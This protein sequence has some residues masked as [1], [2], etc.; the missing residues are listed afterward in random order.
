MSKGWIG[1]L[2]EWIEG[3]TAYLSVAFTWK[4]PEALERAAWF[5]ASGYRVVAGGPGLFVRKDF[6]DGVAEVG[7]IS[8]GAL[9]AM[10]AAEASHR[11]NCPEWNG[12]RGRGGECG[13]CR[14]YQ[15]MLAEWARRQVK[16]PL[17][18]GLRLR[19]GIEDS[20]RWISRRAAMARW[21][22]ALYFEGRN[23]KDAI[24]HVREALIEQEEHATWPKRKRRGSRRRGVA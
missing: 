2:A 19:P 6:L 4:L 12:Q 15:A 21:A 8:S 14:H 7:M 1:G 10:A 18:L 20:R 17:Q 3:D 11:R 16:P 9:S 24:A 23:Y 22:E 13:D 5:K